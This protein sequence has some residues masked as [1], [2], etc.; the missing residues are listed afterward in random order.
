MC[1][2]GKSTSRQSAASKAQSIRL[3]TRLHALFKDCGLRHFTYTSGRESA[4][5]SILLEASRLAQVKADVGDET[6]DADSEYELEDAS[7]KPEGKDVHATADAVQAAAPGTSSPGE[8]QRNGEAERPIQLVEDLPRTLEL[9][10]EDR[11]GAKIPSNHHVLEW[12]IMYTGT[13]LTT[14]HVSGEAQTTRY[15]RL[16][17]ETSRERMPGLGDVVYVFAPSKYRSTWDARCRI[18][19]YLGRNWNSNQNRM[20][21]PSGDVTRARGMVRLVEETRWSMHKIRTQC[22][23]SPQRAPRCAEP[24]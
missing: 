6:E 8:S 18:G 15:Q 17:G 3:T 2:L 14:W 13:L 16:H 23:D 12:L 5:R 7:P 20:G 9:C 24:H 21:L 11:L 4:I 19:V 22:D 10:R 1:D